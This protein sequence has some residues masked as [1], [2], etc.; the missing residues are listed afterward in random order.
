MMTS[1]L[2][3]S[4]FPLFRS[5]IYWNL[6]YSDTD[7]SGKNPKNDP[8]SFALIEEENKYMPE[9]KFGM[10][11]DIFIIRTKYLSEEV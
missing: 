1:K 4:K 11:G 5:G 8:I 7:I 6:I 10:N 3:I 9:K 2:I